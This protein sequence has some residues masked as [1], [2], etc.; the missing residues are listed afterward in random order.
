MNDSPVPAAV[1]LPAAPE[2]TAAGRALLD[3]LARHRSIRRYKPDAIDSA[4]LDGI[5]AR[6]IAGTSSSGNLNMVSIVRTQREERRR[7]LWELHFEQ[8]MILQAPVLLTFCA[9]THRTRTWLAQRGARLNF[10]NFVSYHVAAFDA[11]ILAQTVA[12]A[13]EAH[14]LGICYLGTTVESMRGIGEFL[15]LPDHCVPVTTLVV[16]HP[17]EAP[18]ARDRLAVDAYVHDE[19]YR[20]HDAADIDRLYVERERKGWERYRAIGPEFALKI[21]QAGITSLAQFYTSQLKYDPD[22]FA[23]F[24]A[25]LAA[26]LAEKGFM[27]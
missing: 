4:W 8:D 17:D 18:P 19:V 20:A 23:G 11:M 15:E 3:L 2:P 14:G 21:E 7:R 13:L 10:G 5:C 27:P 24:S 6:A 1:P 16:G 25:A 22:A 26:V 9:D 12:L